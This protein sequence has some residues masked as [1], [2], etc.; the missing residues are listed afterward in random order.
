MCCYFINRNIYSLSPFS[1]K[2]PLGCCWCPQQAQNKKAMNNFLE[3]YIE[4]KKA[5][6][7]IEGSLPSLSFIDSESFDLILTANLLFVYAPISD[8]GLTRNHTLFNL[9][10]TLRCITELTRLIK[11]GGE[12]RFTPIINFKL[13]SWN[14]EHPYLIPVITH[15]ETLGFICDIKYPKS[16]IYRF[17]KIIIAR[18]CSIKHEFNTELKI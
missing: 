8:G 7:Y 14:E 4:G 18:K 1:W 6:R 9:K 5:G 15:L 3:D 13:C 17:T 16:Y 2:F 10:G 11:P 12:I